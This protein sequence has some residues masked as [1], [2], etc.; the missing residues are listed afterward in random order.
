M[1]HNNIYNMIIWFYW[2]WNYDDNS[3]VLCW[4]KQPVLCCFI[5]DYMVMTHYVDYILYPWIWGILYT[6]MLCFTHIYV[7][8]FYITRSALILCTQ[9]CILAFIRI[10]FVLSDIN[11]LV[12]WL[13]FYRVS[14]SSQNKNYIQ[15]NSC[16]FAKSNMSAKL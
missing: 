11:I 15:E 5:F 2:L 1:L 14:F 10:S 4:F 7:V 16:R 9:L 3:F 6:F 8:L 12:K 13:T